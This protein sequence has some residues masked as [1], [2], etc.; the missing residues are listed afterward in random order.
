MSHP[1]PSRVPYKIRSGRERRSLTTY[2]T[3][4]TYYHIMIQRNYKP[5][6]CLVC[7]ILVYVVNTRHVRQLST[8][9]TLSNDMTDHENEG[10]T[11]SNKNRNMRNHNNN[12][13]NIL[14]SSNHQIMM[15]TN[16]I[17]K[18][19]A[20]DHTAVNTA[21]SCAAIDKRCFIRSKQQYPSQHLALCYFL[22][23]G[24]N[25]GDELGMCS[26]YL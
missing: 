7:V 4:R 14:L 15:K 6:V 9:Y 12:N 11:N 24:K 2:D 20:V 13:K 26:Y 22:P 10:N 3:T 8:A 1:P 5:I 18:T 19:N 23:Y 25:F 16:P 17:H 21:S